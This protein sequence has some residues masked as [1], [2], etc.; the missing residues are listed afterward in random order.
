MQTLST[1]PTLSAM[2]TPARL[3]L[4]GSLILLAG[5]YAETA[6]HEGPALRDFH[7]IDSYGVSSEEYNRPRLAINPYVDEGLFEILWTAQSNRDY[8]LGFY[9]NDRPDIN[10][11]TFVYGELCGRG[12]DCYHSGIRLCQYYSDFTLAC[13]MDEYVVNIDY[14]IKRIP[15][16]LYAFLEV[17]DTRTS[18]CEYQYRPVLME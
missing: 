15:Q 4:M 5:C 16:T 6:P 12:L 8:T 13:G 3:A 14:L 10:G 11:S 9:I 7:M 2:K 18:Y 1:K 17:C